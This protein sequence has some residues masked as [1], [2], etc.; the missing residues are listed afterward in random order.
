MNR[1]CRMKR[2]GAMV[3]MSFQMPKFKYCTWATRHSPPSQAGRCAYPST[4][5]LE[6]GLEYGPVASAS[7]AESPTEESF[8]LRGRSCARSTLRKGPT[9]RKA[10]EGRGRRGKFEEGEG[11]SRKATDG[12]GRRRKVE[13]DEGRLMTLPKS[14]NAKDCTC[15]YHSRAVDS[16][17]PAAQ[18][19]ATPSASPQSVTQSSM[20]EQGHDLRM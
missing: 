19:S 6:Q 1:R 12:Q 13:G 18:S 8:L 3:R 11:R 14:K 9:S 15:I 5:Y 2:L 4:P 17:Q 10:R 16:H 20:P 7:D